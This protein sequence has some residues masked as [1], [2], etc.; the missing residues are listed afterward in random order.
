MR[1]SNDGAY[2]GR[3]ENRGKGKELPTVPGLQAR[4]ASMSVP[5]Q[6]EFHHPLII[7]ITHWLNAIALFI[8][9][10]SGLRIY[11]ASPLFDFSFPK[12]ITFGG[13]LAGA[14][15]WHFFAMWLFVLNGIIYVFYNVFSKHGRRTTLFGRS[16]IGGVFPMVLYYLR[17]RKEHPPQGKYNSLQKLAYTVVPFLALGG[18]LSGIAIYWPVQF[19]SIAS[20]FGGYE[21]ARLW[22][23]IFMSLLVIFT[24]GHL[25]MVAIAG[26]NNFLSMITGWRRLR[27][28]PTS[29]DEE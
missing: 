14:R 9:I 13:W 6:R 24:A 15:Q 2:K 23:F 5:S 16:D 29:S 17:I 19:S 27:P 10:T 21:N 4:R 12:E 7:R 8:M 3:N 26:W 25:F 11:N 1:S 22:H 18:V 28:M 20:L